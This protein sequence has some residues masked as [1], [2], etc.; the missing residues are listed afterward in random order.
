IIL[1]HNSTIIILTFITT[2][3]FFIIIRSIYNKLI[4]RFLLE[5][6]TIEIIYE[7]SDFTNIS[8]DSFII[9]SN[10]LL[11]NK[12]RLLN[13]DNRCTRV[14]PEVPDLTYRWRL[15]Y[16]KITVG[17]STNFLKLNYEV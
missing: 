7:Y 9:P 10:Q 13:V 2:L 11:P 1:F 4:N 14:V 5:H 16:K 6:Q 15:L 8:F 12:F 17:E 3:I